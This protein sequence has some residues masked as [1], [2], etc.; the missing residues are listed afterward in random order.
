MTAPVDL[1]ELKRLLADRQ[2]KKGSALEGNTKIA[3]AAFV[4]EHCDALIA[5]LEAAREMID[6]SAFVKP[7]SKEMLDQIYQVADD[8]GDKVLE[9]PCVHVWYLGACV[10]CE[11]LVRDY[12]LAASE[13][14]P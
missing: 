9:R 14:K 10:H 13:E 3:L 7:P 11:I 2:N 6:Y 1:E 5:E 8:A 4:M 12:R